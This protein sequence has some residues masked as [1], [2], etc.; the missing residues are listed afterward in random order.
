MNY[1]NALKNRCCFTQFR[2]IENGFTR[3]T[4]FPTAAPDY[5]FDVSNAINY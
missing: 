3:K 5:K 1:L 4:I 2:K